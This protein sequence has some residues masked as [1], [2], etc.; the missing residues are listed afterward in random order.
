MSPRNRYINQSANSLLFKLWASVFRTPWLF[1][2]KTIYIHRTYTHT[3]IIYVTKKVIHWGANHPNKQSSL[4]SPF[5]KM[6][7]LFTFFKPCEEFWFSTFRFCFS[8]CASFTLWEACLYLFHVLFC[9]HHSLVMTSWK[10]RNS[11]VQ[12]LTLLWELLKRQFNF[13]LLY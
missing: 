4:R 2:S 9:Q 3:F 10:S 13:R 1:K 8:F 12:L 7:L 6:R 5:W 11:F